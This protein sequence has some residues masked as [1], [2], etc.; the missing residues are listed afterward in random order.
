MELIS[1]DGNAFPP[2][3]SGQDAVVDFSGN[4]AVPR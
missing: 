4:F 1:A 3:E 2:G